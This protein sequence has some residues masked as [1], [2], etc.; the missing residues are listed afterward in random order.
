MA[1]LVAG[2]ALSHSP[3]LNVPP[4]DFDVQAIE[5]YKQG[6][7]TLGEAVMAGEPDVLIVIAQD[8]FRTH[9]YDLMPAITIGTGRV[10]GWGDWGTR[11]GELPA[12]AHLARHLHRHLLGA[13][14]DIASSYDLTVD[15]GVTQ[16]IELLGLP[17]SL[18]IIP[19]LINTSA[20]PLPVP[21][22]CYQLGNAIADALRAYRLPVRVAIL[23]SGGISHAPPAGNVESE[24][25]AQAQ[26]VHDLIHGHS[27]VLANEAGRQ[28]RLIAAVKARK[29]KHSV[30]PEWDRAILDSFV[31]GQ[32]EQLAKTLD[33]ASIEAQGGGGGQEIRTWLAAAAA[34]GGVNAREICYYP[35]ESLITGMGVIALGD[36]EG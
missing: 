5:D 13:C 10:A 30:R 16:P 32:A 15:H 7:R 9:F 22:R 25:P 29:F 33:E 12:D 31:N 19:V 1:V 3:L 6:A 2:G 17:D 14:F 4:L 23:G 27:K 28:Q 36:N 8:H 20:P 18:P 11:S 24:D 35:I 26:A 21:Q 34:Y